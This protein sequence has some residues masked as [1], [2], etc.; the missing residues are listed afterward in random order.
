MLLK[1]YQNLSPKLQLSLVL[2]QICLSAPS[3]FNQLPP[4]GYGYSGLEL[5]GGEGAVCPELHELSEFTRE[6]Q[7]L[8]TWPG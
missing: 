7:A 4:S 5:L 2:V 1:T 8:D 3:N 6:F